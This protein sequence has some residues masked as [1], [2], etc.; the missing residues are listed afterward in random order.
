MVSM[1][2]RRQPI[3]RKARQTRSRNSRRTGR[4][5]L[6]QAFH[7][8]NLRAKQRANRRMGRRDGLTSIRAAIAGI[9]FAQVVSRPLLIGI[10]FAA[11]AA[12][13]TPFGY[14]TNLLVYGPGG[15]RFGDYLRLG[16]P[17]N[18]MYV[19]LSVAL[20]PVLYPF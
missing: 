6:R 10:M 8:A 20:I 18:L 5:T 13:Y 19:L 11:S 4:P 16:G 14:Q 9:D 7:D 2:P 17:L 12:F 15:Y 1:R 3:A